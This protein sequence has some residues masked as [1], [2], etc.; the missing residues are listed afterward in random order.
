MKILILYRH[1]PVAMGRYIHWGLQEAGHEVMSI[2][3]YSKGNIPWA[4]GMEMPNHKYPPNIELQGDPPP[5]TAQEAINEARKLGFK[6]D[7]FIQAADTFALLGDTDIP[8]I[9][10]GTDPHAIDYLPFIKD[11]DDFVTMQKF[12][13]PDKV[14]MPYAYTPSINRYLPDEVIRYHVVFSGLQYDHRKD[15]LRALSDKGWNVFSGI[16]Y[17]YDAYNRLYNSG[18][19]AFNWSS[20]QDLPARFWEGMAA[21]RCVLTNRVP[22]LKE[23]DFKEGT[24][25][26]GF[27]TLDEAVEKA[28]FYLKHQDLLFKIADNG[29]KK[30][31]NHTWKNRVEKMLQ[32]VMND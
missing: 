17:V 11:A 31:K 26:L 1:F 8:N 18:M 19:I 24:D 10:I 15:A 13:H 4:G 23:L 14:W 20:K 21:K 6:P 28:S 22:D 16:G 9:V 3:P 12:Y 32:E 27:D 25:Y 29:Y 7:A 30:V 2:G 5:V